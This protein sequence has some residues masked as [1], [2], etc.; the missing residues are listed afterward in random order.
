MTS[1]APS[2]AAG[3]GGEVGV[4]FFE[5]CCFCAFTSAS[6]CIRNEQRTKACS[7]MK[8]DSVA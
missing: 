2:L 6:D 1:A 8:A 5:S 4:P 3:L 7:S